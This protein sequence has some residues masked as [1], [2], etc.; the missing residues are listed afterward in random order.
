M[1]KL[2]VILMSLTVLLIVS[3]CSGKNVYSSPEAVSEEMVKLLSKGNY[4][5]AKKLLYNDEG[6]LFIDDTSF[7][8]YLDSN[9]LV[10]KGNKKIEL[11][12]DTKE[13]EK[14]IT[15]KTVK[16]KIDDNRIFELN[17]KLKDKKWAIDIGKSY[18][19][20]DLII[21]VPV[22]SVVKLNGT[23]LD[24]KNYAKNEKVKQKVSYNGNSYEFES[25][26]DTY[27]IDKLL[28]GT[29]ELNVTND[30]IKSTSVKI[31][32][33]RSSFR[34][35]DSDKP[36]FETREKTA[37]RLL[38]VMDNKKSDAV[39]D[40][41]KSYFNALFEEV[42]KETPS[43][44]N[45]KSY[46]K[47]ADKFS[48]VFNKLVEDKNKIKS[49]SE[50]RFSNLKLEGINK[51]D[52]Y[53]YGDDNIIICLDVKVSYHYTF[54]YVGF[55]ASMNDNFHEDKDEEKNAKVLLS[56][57]ANGDKYVI[58]GGLNPVPYVF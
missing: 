58:Q 30:N 5:E 23:T 54:K 36:V 56:I 7:E 32:S 13:Y 18:Y 4:K 40:Y 27:T 38:P 11:V 39:L 51:A 50:A 44:D 1:K 21:Q 43:L 2:K 35:E 20:T 24:K 26:I 16:V 3:G 42:N 9:K 31:N 57:S 45:M 25:D 29:Y 48:N 15:S 6:N 14:D 53:Y 17:T 52:T 41:A 19:D 37:Y 12:K 33:R 8:N 46:Y 22:G 55:M 49:Y 47:D 28:R 10:I 34:E